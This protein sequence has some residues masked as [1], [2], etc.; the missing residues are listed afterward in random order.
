MDRDLKA[1]VMTALALEHEAVALRVEHLRRRRTDTGSRLPLPDG[2]LTH[3]IAV[4]PS[5]KVRPSSGD[6]NGDMI[7]EATEN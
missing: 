4:A 1:V 2:L 5:L 6:P 3:A 7:I